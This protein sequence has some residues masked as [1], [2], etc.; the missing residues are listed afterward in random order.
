M[1]ESLPPWPIPG[2]RIRVGSALDRATLVKFMQHNYA[3]LNASPPRHHIAAT[4]DRYLSPNTPLWWVEVI[5]ADPAS[6]PVGCIWLGQATDQRQGLL[7]PYVLLLYVA[8][9]HR[10]RGIATTLLHR[11][12][13]WAKSVGNDQISLQ[14]FSDNPGAQTLYQKLGYQPEAILMKKPLD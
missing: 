8:P 5:N 6:A 13:A 12:H 14:V 4:V 7:H 1:A 11:A 10:R 9:I 2:Y 3:E